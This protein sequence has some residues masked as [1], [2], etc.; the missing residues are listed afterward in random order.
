[1]TPLH[2]SVAQGFLLIFSLLASSSVEAQIYPRRVSPTLL[3]TAPYNSTGM[4]FA[5]INGSWR[6]SAVVARDPRL[7]Y[8]CAH[9]VYDDGLW[10]TDVRFI[11]R[12]HSSAR[13]L[14]SQTVAVRGYRY[15]APYGGTNS[16]VDFSLDFSIGYGGVGTTFGPAV[17][18]LEDGTAHLRNAATSKIVLGYPATLDYTSGSGF[19]YQHITGPFSAGMTQSYDSYHTRAGISTGPGNS[20]GPVLANVGGKYVLAGI[21]VSGSRTTM[22]VHGLDAASSTMAKNIL[23]FLAGTNSANTRTV[24]N[25]SSLLLPDAATTYSSR[26]LVVSGI[27]ATTTATTFSLRVNT[28]YRGDLDVYVRSP[29]GR[30]KWVKKH[31]IAGDGLNLIVNNATYTSTFAGANPNGTWKLFMRD[32]YWGDRATFKEAT[33]TVTSL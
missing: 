14:S 3:E 30:I 13:P 29:S 10:A 6:G 33:L 7:L 2:K 1:M 20:G 5:E 27:P 28:P 31:D 32:F 26:S 23:T 9:V 8:S 17:G 11:R 15:Y 22:G 4:V 25:T 16:A 18:Y 12:W 24:A 21:L 19:H